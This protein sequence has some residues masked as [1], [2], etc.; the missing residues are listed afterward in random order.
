MNKKVKMILKNPLFLFMTFEL[1]F[2]LRCKITKKI[3]SVL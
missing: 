3:V 1:L 2:F